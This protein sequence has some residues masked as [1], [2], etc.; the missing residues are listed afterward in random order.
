MHFMCEENVCFCIHLVEYMCIHMYICRTEYIYMY[1]HVCRWKCFNLMT[2]DCMY[3]YMYTAVCVKSFR[4]LS[5][6]L[7]FLFLLFFRI[8]CQNC[9]RYRKKFIALVFVFSVF[10][11]CLLYILIFSFLAL[12]LYC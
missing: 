6:S 4:R 9:H 1:M 11:F 10:F 7:R 2:F 5:D 3:V 12:P 8:N